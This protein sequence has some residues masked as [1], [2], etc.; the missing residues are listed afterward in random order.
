M[1]DIEKY[2]FRE[3]WRHA[4]D[5]SDD[6]GTKNG[7]AIV[8]GGEIIAYGTNKMLAGVEKTEERL[9]RP[10]L[11]DWIFHAERD[12]LSNARKDLISLADAKMYCSWVP[13][14]NCAQE[15]VSSGIGEIIFHTETNVF[16]DKNPSSQ[17]WV[18]N[19]TLILFDAAKH[20]N[21][22]FYS[23]KIFDDDFSIKFRGKDF[24]P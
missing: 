17:D 23:G 14:I 9:T 18:Q 6:S 10:A 19:K 16:A 2:Y 15:I 11:Y 20:I 24:S 12:G 8:R 7:V 21:Y 3:A 4:R 13:C 5:N 22:R 1:E